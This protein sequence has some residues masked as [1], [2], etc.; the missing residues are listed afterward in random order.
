MTD[1][2]SP[3]TP[4]I[5]AGRFTLRRLIREDTPALFPTLSDEAQCRFMSR[6]HF[7]A[8]DELAD[9]LTDAAWPGRSWVAVDKSDGSVAGRYVAF[10]GRDDG[11]LELG[12]VTVMARQG[13]GV[14]RDCMA[15]LIDHLFATGR[16]RKLYLEIDAENAASVA[17]AE[18]LG[19]TREACL[20]EHEITHK[21]LCDL[22]IYGLL[23]GEWQGKDA[24]AT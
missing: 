13:Q 8:M 3:D 21:G 23:R 20:R 1:T 7:E 17:L 6:P 4:T 14:A 16:Y 18:R 15:A 12:Y 11:A 19:F 2:H 10:S 22:L 9:W 24:P 5:D